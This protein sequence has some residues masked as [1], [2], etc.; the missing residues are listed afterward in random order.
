MPGK[1]NGCSPAGDWL[2]QVAL[3]VVGRVHVASTPSF[4]VVPEPPGTLVKSASAG[5]RHG[6]TWT[7][8]AKVWPAFRRGAATWPTIVSVGVL[9]GS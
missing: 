6:A 3:V 8:Q 1:E 7:F 9:A 2:V 5:S 4:A